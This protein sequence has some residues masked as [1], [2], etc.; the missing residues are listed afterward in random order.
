MDVL[1]TVRSVLERVSLV[2]QVGGPVRGAPQASLP[3]HGAIPGGG[4]AV[5]LNFM[6]AIEDLARFRYSR[7]VWNRRVVPI[8]QARGGGV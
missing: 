4:L 5:T 6:T 8:A 2:A 3:L 1:L 7:D